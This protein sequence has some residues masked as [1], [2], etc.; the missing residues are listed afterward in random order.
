M[1]DKHGAQEEKGPFPKLTEYGAG[2][3]PMLPVSPPLIIAKPGERVKG[4]KC[5]VRRSVVPAGASPAPA[6]VVPAG[7]SCDVGYARHPEPFPYDNTSCV[8]LVAAKRIGAFSLLLFLGKRGVSGS[9][10]KIR[11]VRSEFPVTLKDKH[12]Q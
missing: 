7:C 11:Q 5:A 10:R 2:S 12:A 3:G 9:S 4:T 1:Q 6:K 8:W